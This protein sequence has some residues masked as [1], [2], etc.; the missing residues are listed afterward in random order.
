MRQIRVSNNSLRR[1][2]PGQEEFSTRLRVVFGAGLGKLLTD[3]N[4]SLQ[5]SKRVEG[6][7]NH[8]E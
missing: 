8:A 7:F 2:I 3:A 1:L 4:G 5:P 6:G